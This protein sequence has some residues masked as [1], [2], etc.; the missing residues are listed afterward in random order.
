MAL[1]K[2]ISQQL[3]DIANRL[4]INSIRSTNAA[5]SGH[6]TSCASM[7]EIMAVLFFRTMR[8]SIDKPR[9]AS[10]DRFILS[11][12]HAA[13]ILYAA[14]AESGLF[15]VEDLLNLRKIDSDLEGHPTPRL[16]FVDV[17]TGSLGQG[18]SIAAGMAYVGKYIDKA[19]YRV[20]CLIGDGESA[21]G[22]IWEALSF[23]S[24]YKLDNLVAIF[25]VNRLGQSEPTAFGHDMQ[26]YK[27][28]VETFGFNAI[29]VDGHDVQALVEAFDQASQIKDRPTAVIAQTFK[30]KGLTDEIEDKVNWHGK[31]LGDKAEAIIAQIQSRISTPKTTLKPESPIVNVPDVDLSVR[32][33]EPPNYT[34]G[35]KV[36][37]RE[38][39]GTALV[40]L[41]KSCP[42]V[43]GLDGDTK[44]STFS[45]TYRKTFQDRFIECYIAEQ[46]LVGVAIGAGCRRRTIPFVST[47]ASFFTRTFD[48]LR[49]GAI[50]QANIKCVGSHCGVSIG[51]DGPSQMALED[52]AM[53]RAIP[54]SLVFYPSDAVSVERA[55]E[56]AAQ[57]HGITFIRTSRPA[58][59]IIYSND[60][61]FAVGKAKVVRSS[62]NDQILLIGACVTLL[63][64][65]NAADLLAK[66]H[67]IQARIIDPFTIKPIDR[68]TIIKN[69]LEAGGRIITI[70]DHYPEGGIGEAVAGVIAD[71]PNIV[72]KRL[73][74]REIPRSGPP[75]V[76]IEKYGIDAKTIVKMA[77]E[78]IEKK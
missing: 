12:G 54:N 43:I 13:P 38:A 50:S 46:N 21:E 41:G 8:Y 70:E 30:G 34:I 4:R 28:R 2:E 7:A 25:D 76:L 42:R 23:A 14:W 36:A 32:L 69:A 17:A 68:E 6:P 58:T 37:T 53:F 9:G 61:I 40:K 3:Q 39:Y 1:T 49:M 63:E 52:L 67:N 75:S 24:K 72:M 45:D 33:V 74:I 18:L 48:Q 27:A 19:P 5:K 71:I 29:V 47:F 65:M 35:Q 22:S 51:E 78:M 60:E 16:N 66:N 73:A 44:N 57:Y 55:A 20:Y 10:N 56:L 15:P 26:L 59:P 62:K 64:A 31:P 77:L 11:K